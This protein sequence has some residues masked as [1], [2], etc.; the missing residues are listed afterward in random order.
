MAAMSRKSLV[1][2]LLLALPGCA[3]RATETQPAASIP[4]ATEA[5]RGLQGTWHGVL[6]GRELATASGISD[7]RE[8]LTIHP[9]GTWSLTSENG[10]AVGSIV[11]TTRN[12]VLLD[13]RF[14]AGGKAPAGA[15]VRYVLVR[16]GAR[17][18][19]GTGDD[20]FL[21]HGVQGNAVFQRE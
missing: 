6:T 4:P 14:T 10:Q 5:A 18:L 17:G 11:G 20:F 12:G 8:T 13:G 21:G 19:V 1:A 2:V 16:Q 15:P 9:D 3:A 7:V